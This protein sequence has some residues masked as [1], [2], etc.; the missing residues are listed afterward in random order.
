MKYGVFTVMLPDLTPEE[1]AP[2]LREAGYDGIEWRVT[3]VPESKRGDTPSFWGNNLCTL[4][5][6][7]AEARRGRALAEAAGL[8]IPSVSPYLT[9]GD[10]AATEQ[11]MQFAQVAGAPQMRVGVGSMATGKPYS[12]LF[13][14]TRAYLGEVEKMGARY[15]VKGLVEIHHGLISASASLAFRLVDGFDPARVGVIYDVGNMVHEG[16]EDHRIGLELLGPYLAHV[17]VKNAAYKAPEGGGLW[18]G[19]W[20]PLENGVVNFPQFV[21][22]LRAVKYD[23]WICLEDFSQAR[24]TREALRHNLA[25][26][27]A[28]VDPVTA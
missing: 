20:S 23:G 25:F 4:D 26:I 6:T 17:H 24:P 27:K 28:L 12:E 5:V 15:G 10:L 1:A 8:V 13:R 2:A 3:H 21:A 7:E 14:E 16:Y 22:G 9:V 18:T 19:H 11:A